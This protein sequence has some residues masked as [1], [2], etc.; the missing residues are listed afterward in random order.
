M[1]REATPPSTV[2]WTILLPS[3]S[4]PSQNLLSPSLLLP[5]PQVPRW[6]PS[7][8]PPSPTGL[9]V[10]V[11]YGTRPVVQMVSSRLDWP[12]ID[13]LRVWNTC[14][15]WLLKTNRDSC[16]VE[17]WQALNRPRYCTAYTYSFVLYCAVMYCTK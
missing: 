6:P 17:R 5:Q 11:D 2:L 9:C 15:L 4:Q 10:K 1:W 7:A 14:W 13:L 3:L 8:P 12:P 16:A